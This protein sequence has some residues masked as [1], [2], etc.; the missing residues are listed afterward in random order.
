MLTC[1][2]KGWIVPWKIN[3]LCWI[4]PALF[5]T[6]SSGTHIQHWFSLPPPQ[7]L[8]CGQW[9]HSQG[10]RKGTLVFLGATHAV[11]H[12]CRWIPET[13]LLLSQSELRDGPVFSGQS[14]SKLPILLLLL[15]CALPF[16]AQEVGRGEGTMEVAVVALL[17]KWGP[18]FGVLEGLQSA[19]PGTVWRLQVPQSRNKEDKSLSCRR[20]QLCL[21]KQKCVC[22]L[23]PDVQCKF[24]QPFEEDELGGPWCI[25]VC[26]FPNTTTTPLMFESK[27][28]LEGGFCP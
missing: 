22:P 17:G 8:L 24:L 14:I 9:P 7:L 18:A 27:L 2:E 3:P 21:Y 1:L 26:W 4:L 16:W 28:M 11:A 10:G 15:W 25:F 13:S 19:P 20:R 12:S 6:Y 5:V 23:P